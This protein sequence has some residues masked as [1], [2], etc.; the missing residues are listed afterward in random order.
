MIFFKTF[1]QLF[2]YQALFCGIKCLIKSVGSYHV[3]ESKM[4]WG[5]VFP[6]DDLAP[7]TVLLPLRLVLQ[8]QGNRRTQYREERSPRYGCDTKLGNIEDYDSL[9]SMVTHM[10]LMNT[11]Q[12]MEMVINSFILY[13][14]LVAMEYLDR[15][16][17]MINMTCLL[18]Q[19]QAVVR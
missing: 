14:C 9:H 3:Y 16:E 15:E 18:Y 2:S 12:D 10:D 8:R 13:Q 11:K 4:N 19:Y 1:K 17:N 7:T 6:A 5:K